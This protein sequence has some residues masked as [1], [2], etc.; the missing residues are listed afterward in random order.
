MVWLCESFT[1]KV[2]GVDSDSSSRVLGFETNRDGCVCAVEARRSLWL[3]DDRG[4]QWAKG[5]GVFITC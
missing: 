3:Y 2:S 1:I 5:L 4:A